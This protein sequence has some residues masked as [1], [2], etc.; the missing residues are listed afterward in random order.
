MNQRG[1]NTSGPQKKPEKIYPTLASVFSSGN[2]PQTSINNRQN[3]DVLLW[4]DYI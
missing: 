2:N 4:N 1:L 3:S